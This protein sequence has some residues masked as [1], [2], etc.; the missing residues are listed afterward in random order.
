MRV[1]CRLGV[2]IALRQFP[3]VQHD[4]V[5]QAGVMASEIPNLGVRV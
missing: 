2:V 5:F 3:S 4:L 1:Q